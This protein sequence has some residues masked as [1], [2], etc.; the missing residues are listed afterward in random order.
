M[1]PSFRPKNPPIRLE[2][3][4]F[5]A[6]WGTLGHSHL[7]ISNAAVLLRAF[8]GWYRHSVLRLLVGESRAL[9][10]RIRWVL[11]I[12]ELQ[13]GRDSV[14]EWMSQAL[15]SGSQNYKRAC[16]HYMQQI[17]SRYQFLSIFDL[18]L[19]Q[20]AW[21]AGSEWNGLGTLRIVKIRHIRLQRAAILCRP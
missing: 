2:V 14:R 19:L 7:P 10:H 8:L 5:R 16:I 6:P 18:F 12:V 13:R 4:G 1:L 3:T 11:E 9:G 20:Q 17:E 21:K 15:V